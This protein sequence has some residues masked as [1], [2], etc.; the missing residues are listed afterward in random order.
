[1]DQYFKSNDNTD[2]IWS[3]FGMTSYQIWSYH[4]THGKKFSFLYSKSYS[5]L[6]FRKSRQ[7]LW[8]F[9]IPNGTYKEDN[10]KVSRICALSPCGIEWMPFKQRNFVFNL[11]FL[12][13][14]SVDNN[15]NV[16]CPKCSWQLWYLHMYSKLEKS[17]HNPIW[18]KG[19][20]HQESN[21]VELEADQ[22]LSREI[23]FCLLEDLFHILLF[24]EAEVGTVFH[25]YMLK[26][27]SERHLH[28]VSC[29]LELDFSSTRILSDK[30]QLWF[31]WLRT[32]ILV[33]LFQIEP[34]DTHWMLSVVSFGSIPQWCLKKWNQIF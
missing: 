20:N 7:I 29:R 25:L 23:V 19:Y 2:A 12:K 26:F 6:N 17:A 24:L 28:Q 10:L 31:C 5:L 34:T 8:F 16:N 13:G 14:E 9:C 3:L 21:S 4:L 1:M 11:E 22:L 18:T 32:E 33:H 15:L 27:H 30:F